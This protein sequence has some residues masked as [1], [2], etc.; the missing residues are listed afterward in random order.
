MTD[1]DQ[2]VALAARRAHDDEV[3]LI[4]TDLFKT[5]GAPIRGPRAFFDARRFFVAASVGEVRK[6]VDGIV[7]RAGGDWSRIAREV[8]AL[9]KRY[10][11]ANADEAARRACAYAQMR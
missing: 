8:E 4:I 3:E 10:G 7:E 11:V 9:L 5:C 6:A 1:T 2:D